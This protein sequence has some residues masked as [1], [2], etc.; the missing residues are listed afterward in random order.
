V[1]RHYQNPPIVEALVE[2]F[3]TGSKQGLAVRDAFLPRVQERF[4]TGRLLGQVGFEVNVGP[5]Q[6]NARF[7]QAEPRFQFLT[8]DQS[9]MIQLGPDLLVFNLLRPNPQVPYPRF[10]VWQPIVLEMLAHYREVA[11]PTG[12]DRLGVRYINKVTIP[13]TQMR[14]EEYFT[15]YPQV[16]D[17]LGDQHGSFLMNLELPGLYPNHQ[18]LLTFGSTS[19]EQPEAM[20][21]LLDLYDIV[22]MGSPDSF[23]LIPQRLD[24]AHNNIVTTFEYAITDTTRQLFG[25]AQDA[26]N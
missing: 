14:M 21:Y 7:S 9:Q 25:E 26:S 19:P 15:I 8:S 22:P 10:E 6:A 18:L 20:A 17:T 16:P 4:P 12:I 24:E 3:F 23:E 11:Q 5:K 2:I 13:Q 1:R